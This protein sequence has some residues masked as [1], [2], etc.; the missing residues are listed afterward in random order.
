MVLVD[1]QGHEKTQLENSCGPV[2]LEQKQ[3]TEKAASRIHSFS[4]KSISSAV[5]PLSSKG[6]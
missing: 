3:K 6:P 4:D 1:V 5:L 2:D